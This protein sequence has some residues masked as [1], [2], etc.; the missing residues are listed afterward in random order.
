MLDTES[1]DL[2]ETPPGEHSREVYGLPSAASAEFPELVAAISVDDT[3]RVRALVGRNPALVGERLTLQSS[4]PLTLA[5]HECSIGAFKALLDAKA[6]PAADHHAALFKACTRDCPEIVG[7]LI[8]C[9]ADVNAEIPAYGP[10]L[11][12]ACECHA[13]QCARLLLEH[14][15]DPNRRSAGRPAVVNPFL[16]TPLGMA[17]GTQ[18]RSSHLH[19]LVNA[20]ID[21]GASYEAGPAMDLHRGDLKSFRERVQRDPA[22][23]RQH[24]SLPYGNTPLEGATLLHVAAEYGE[25][26]AAHV[27]LDA[28]TPVD[29]RAGERPDG[30]T[31]L[32]HAAASYENFGLEM[33]RLLLERGADPNAEAA[34]DVDGSSRIYTP[35]SWARVGPGSGTSREEIRLLKQHGAHA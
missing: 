5:A 22:L 30:V 19:A 11:M 23:P 32:F 15:A 8:E 3:E 26:E 1:A 2:I 10:V 25:V 4:L 27:L 14:G 24:F 28:G 18:V 7:L 21:A 12:A 20:L 33:L 6:D 13:L 31:P 35:L 9:G 29:A 17:I 34:I 16:A